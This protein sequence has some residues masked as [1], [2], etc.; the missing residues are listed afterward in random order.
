MVENISQSAEISLK[1]HK[2][3][4]NANKSTLVLLQDSQAA[5]DTLHK[6]W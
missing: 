3:A 1:L 5:R 6:I 4:K 2:E